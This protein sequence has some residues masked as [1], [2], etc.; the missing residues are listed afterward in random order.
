MI[1]LLVVL[2]AIYALMS[3]YTR[4]KRPKKR[5]GNW[6]YKRKQYLLSQA[7]RCFYDGL[8]I[9]APPGGGSSGEGCI[10]EPRPG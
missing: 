1:G 4:N 3:R 2:V 5:A 7:E 10:V 8:R 9:A 6:K